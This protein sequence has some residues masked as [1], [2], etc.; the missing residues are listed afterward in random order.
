MANAELCGRFEASTFG[1]LVVEDALNE[2]DCGVSAQ[3]NVKY[4]ASQSTMQIQPCFGT[5]RG[6]WPN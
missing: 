3:P 1:V 4:H 6:K 2:I 5:S